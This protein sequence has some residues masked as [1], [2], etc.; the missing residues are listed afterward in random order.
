MTITL[1]C[2]PPCAGKTTYV[3]AYAKPGSL[4]VDYDAIAIALGSPVSHQHEW[5]YARHAA[6]RCH[7][8]IADIED[9]AHPDAW[10]IRSTAGPTAQANL[11]E[12]LSAELVLLLPDRDTL[13]QRA[14]ARPDPRR[15]MVDIDRW[16]AEHACDG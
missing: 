13:H 6:A 7:E 11:A 4:I 15:A 5:R 10:V 8:L 12:R 2:G 14:L 9:G 1:V 16:L 3:N